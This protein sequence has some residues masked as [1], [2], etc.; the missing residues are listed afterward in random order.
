M[1]DWKVV[2][3]R[4]IG[5]VLK[6]NLNW[7]HKSAWGEDIV[8]SEEKQMRFVEAV[9]KTADGERILSSVVRSISSA[10]GIPYRQGSALFKYSVWHK[11]L[12][13]DLSA[14][15]LDLTLPCPT[16]T[17]GPCSS[18]IMKRAA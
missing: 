2:T 8:V 9:V 3:D 13:T 17:A 11:L 1:T 7:L 18:S 6:D 12:L 4:L 16:L 14:T 15:R 10:V 5:P